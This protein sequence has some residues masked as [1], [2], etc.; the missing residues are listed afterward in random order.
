M[1]L[2][3][4]VEGVDA[5][6]K[7]TVVN[8]LK[9]ELRQRG[10]KVFHIHFPNE[11]EYN[12]YAG[13]AS[14][15]HE[16]KNWSVL[17]EYVASFAFRTNIYYSLYP[18]VT[19][20]NTCITLGWEEPKVGRTRITELLASLDNKLIILFDRSIIST[21]VYHNITSDNFFSLD[22]LLFPY[23]HYVIYVESPIELI[24]ERLKNR[25]GSKDEIEKR[26]EMFETLDEKYRRLIPQYIRLGYLHMK[27]S[28]YVRET[29]LIRKFVNMLY[30]DFPFPLQYKE[31]VSYSLLREGIK[32][33]APSW[34][35]RELPNIAI[36]VE[37]EDIEDTIK[38]LYSKEAT[39]IEI[40]NNSTLEDLYEKTLKVL[41]DILS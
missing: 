39:S 3:I 20:L 19:Y 14:L 38:H 4:I 7:G 33:E 5:S 18:P 32:I 2:I 22:L 29:A 11:F 41:K 10:Y 6:G 34:L 15:L 35:K 9:Q 24:E 25:Y 23:P 1:V 27:E 8:I 26:I 12:T 30:E 28:Y 40:S 37:K 21:N 31:C 17:D 13:A 16:R 36:K